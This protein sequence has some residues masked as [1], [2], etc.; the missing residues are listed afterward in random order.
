MHFMYV[1][2]E[3]AQNDLNYHMPKSISRINLLLYHFFLSLKILVILITNSIGSIM[4]IVLASGAVDRGFESQSGQTKDYKIGIFRFSAKYAS[5]RRKSKDWLT[6]NQY[7][8]GMLF[9]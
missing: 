4:V 7:V 8:S 2:G 5:L 9:P 1:L 6:R 3:V